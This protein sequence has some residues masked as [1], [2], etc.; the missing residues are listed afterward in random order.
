[1]KVFLRCMG[2]PMTTASSIKALRARLE[3]YVTDHQMVLNAAVVEI[4]TGGFAAWIPK[5]NLAIASETRA[6]L[7]ARILKEM[8]FDSLPSYRKALVYQLAQYT[9]K[10]GI[11]IRGLH[12]APLDVAVAEF[13]ATTSLLESV[14]AELPVTY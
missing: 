3:S 9:E 10:S 13:Q 11:L 4:T 2:F 12:G 1:M 7:A 14:I 8:E 6:G 5:L